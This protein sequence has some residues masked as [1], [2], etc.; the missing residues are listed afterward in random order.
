MSYKPQLC[1]NCG[2]KLEVPR[3]W[4]HMVVCSSCYTELSRPAPAATERVERVS[5][6]PAVGVSLAVVA[7]VMAIYIVAASTGGRTTRPYPNVSASPTP[8]PPLPSEPEPT[9]FTA[10]PTSFPASA[11]A[12]STNPAS[13]GPAT[14]SSSSGAIAGTSWLLRKEDENVPIRG[15]PVQLLRPTVRRQALLSS[16]S[17]EAATWKYLAD[18]YDDR[19]EEV[20]QMQDEDD[21]GDSESVVDYEQSAEEA[22]KALDRIGVATRAA[23]PEAD[24]AGAFKTLTELSVFNVPRFAD[25]VADTLVTEVRTDAAG[26][27]TFENVPPGVYYVHAAISDGRNFVEWCLPVRVDADVGPV[28][29]DL[30]K[31]TATLIYGEKYGAPALTAKLEPPDS[32]DGSAR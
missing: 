3:L 30:T 31:R 27:Y 17:A 16:L 10:G 25:V 13:T 19:A 1:Q 32:A 24:L 11:P 2:A 26:N 4:K 20:R 23:P 29:V 7:S 5:W 15:L 8:Q 28:Q 6:W 22:V 18:A 9:F 12:P 21:E 14:T